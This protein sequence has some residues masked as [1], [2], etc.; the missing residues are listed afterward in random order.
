MRGGLGH[1]EGPA[2]LKQDA[3][4]GVSLVGPL[5]E[6]LSHSKGMV[7]QRRPGDTRHPNTGIEKGKL[8]SFSIYHMCRPML[9]TGKGQGRERAP[10]LGSGSPEL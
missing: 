7:K 4:H 1:R 9:D 3:Y 8:Q 6:G 5:R 10:A 2:W